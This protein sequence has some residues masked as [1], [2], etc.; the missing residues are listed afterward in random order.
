M[1]KSA[2][3]STSIHIPIHPPCPYD[4]TPLPLSRT[5]TTVPLFSTCRHWCEFRSR[6]YTSEKQIPVW[7]GWVGE[8][9]KGGWSQ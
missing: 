3:P 4:P 8:G 7:G 2:P 9:E 6:M 1:S 5:C